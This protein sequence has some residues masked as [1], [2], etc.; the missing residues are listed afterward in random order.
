[1]ATHEYDSKHDQE[2]VEVPGDGAIKAPSA[3]DVPY[4][5]G[6]AEETALVRKID[7]HMLPM[8]WVMYIFNY[9]DR[10]NIGVSLDIRLEYSCD[11]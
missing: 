10:T 7:R 3:Y 6:T 2:H 9:I 4:V 11:Y 8:L 5:S 1:M